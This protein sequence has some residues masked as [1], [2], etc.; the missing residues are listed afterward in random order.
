MVR[1]SYRPRLLV[2]GFAAG[3]LVSGSA[4]AL[5]STTAPVARAD[6]AVVASVP[7]RRV[8]RITAGAPLHRDPF[9]P[10]VNLPAN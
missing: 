6:D 5:M 8:A 9:V 7:A 10:L 3:L 1:T 2:A 4:C